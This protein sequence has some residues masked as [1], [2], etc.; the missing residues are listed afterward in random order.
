MARVMSHVLAKVGEERKGHRRMVGRRIVVKV[1][2]QRR[3]GARR[4]RR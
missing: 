4:R 1:K 2:G 3:K